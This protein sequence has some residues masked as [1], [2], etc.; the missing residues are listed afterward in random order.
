MTN[1]N[2]QD[3]MS[4]EHKEKKRFIAKQWSDTQVNPKIIESRA[5][6]LA[7]FSSNINKCFLDS[8]KRFKII[9]DYFKGSLT[10][11]FDEKLKNFKIYKVYEEK[12]REN[13]DGIY[14]KSHLT[15]RAGELAENFE[16]LPENIS[17]SPGDFRTKVFVDFFL[18]KFF[19]NAFNDENFENRNELAKFFNEILIEEKFKPTR[20]FLDELTESLTHVQFTE[21]KIFVKNHENFEILT[22]CAEDGLWRLSLFTLKFFDLEDQQKIIKQ[23]KFL[24]IHLVKINQDEHFEF[25]LREILKISNSKFEILQQKFPGNDNDTIWNRIQWKAK[26]QFEIFFRVVGEFLTKEEIKKSVEKAATTSR[27]PFRG[28]VITFDNVEEVF[29]PFLSVE[30][31]REILLKDGGFDKIQDMFE[32]PVTAGQTPNILKYIYKIFT[33][34]ELRKIFG[35]ERDGEHLL[36]KVLPTISIEGEL[37]AFLMSFNLKKISQDT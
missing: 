34:D 11:D 5:E 18:A 37:Q 8:V 33:Q 30:E 20:I 6:Q 17:K 29:K 23:N 21:F 9:T 32:A 24:L 12:S 26:S 1:L 4:E 27:T 10:S 2:P 3:I 15:K 7:I 13:I 28:Y 16:I 25:F 22:K 14:L 35:V 36:H 31:Q 19:F